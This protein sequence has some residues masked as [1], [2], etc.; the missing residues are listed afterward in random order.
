MDIDHLKKQIDEAF[1]KER[2]E[3]EQLTNKFI[4]KV[5][6]DYDETIKK[7]EEE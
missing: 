2:A 1:A 5:K 6:E 3:Q 4:S 7:L